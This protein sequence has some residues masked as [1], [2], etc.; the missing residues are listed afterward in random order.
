MKVF[1]AIDSMRRLTEK[2]ETFSVGFMSYSYEKN[3]SK[4]FIRIEK[5]KLRK[6]HTKERN[7]FTDY[8]LQFLDTS[9]MEYASCWQPLLLEFND[10]ELELT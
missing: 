2:G 9:T 8:M 3:T 5:A 4:G 1:E 7:R 10:N 6:Q